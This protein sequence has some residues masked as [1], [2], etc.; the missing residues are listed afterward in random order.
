MHRTSS[1]GF[2]VVELII[3]IFVLGILTGLLYGPFTNLY[4]ANTTGV[5]KT[6]Q[7]TN[8]HSA[9]RIIESKISESITF[10]DTNDITD[11][12]QPDTPWSWAGTSD[13]SRVLITSNYATTIEESS[14]PSNLRTLVFR[15]PSCDIP[16]TNDYIYFVANNT[17]YRRTLVNTTSPCGGYTN[18]QKQ[19]CSSSATD[20][21]CQ[22]VDA[23]IIS[24]VTEFRVD[25]YSDANNTT[26]MDP[27][28][29]TKHTKYDD[30][31][32]PNMAKSVGITLSAKSG[33]DNSD[34]IYTSTL[35]I[36]RINGNG[37]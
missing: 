35:R 23:K 30:A 7:F 9:L 26:P 19:T 10:A 11:P 18:A 22:G 1:R 14:D 6:A 33:P 8:V 25:Y 34:P 20:N 24:N 17:L 28:D 15:G 29:D 16:V 4:T 21:Y 31:T 32:V 2:T 5:R 3:V 37:N 12:N 27:T 13:T 36:S